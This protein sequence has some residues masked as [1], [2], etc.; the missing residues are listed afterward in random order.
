MKGS[1]PAFFTLKKSL[2][3]IHEATVAEN[4][5]NAELTVEWIGVSD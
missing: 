2:G 5:L 4:Q 3:P 1:S